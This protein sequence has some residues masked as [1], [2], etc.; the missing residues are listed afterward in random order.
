[1]NLRVATSFVVGLLMAAAVCQGLQP[2][3]KMTTETP[4]RYRNSGQ[5]GNAFWHTHSS[6]RCTRQGNRTEGL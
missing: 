2:N 5:T 6:R 1:M 4:T 3:M